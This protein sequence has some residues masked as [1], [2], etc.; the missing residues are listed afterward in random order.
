[1]AAKKLVTVFILN[2]KGLTG[3]MDS[4]GLDDKPVEHSIACVYDDHPDIGT[5]LLTPGKDGVLHVEAIDEA[6][7]NYKKKPKDDKKDKSKDDKK[8]DDKKKDDKDKGNYD[9]KVMTPSK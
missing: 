2:A 3:I 9:T 5:K 4:Q 1:M 6:K 8:K 7:A